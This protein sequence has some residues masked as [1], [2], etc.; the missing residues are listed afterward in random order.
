LSI[1]KLAGQAADF[2]E[3]P[4][5]T[6]LN[7]LKNGWPA[8][9]ASGDAELKIHSVTNPTGVLIGTAWWSGSP[10]YQVHV[11]PVD[12]DVKLKTLGYSRWRYFDSHDV[13]IFAK[14]GSGKDKLW[15]LEKEV[16]KQLMLKVEAPGTGISWMSVDGPRE[17]PE[18]DV[19]SEVYHSVTHVVLC[20]HKIRE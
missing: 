9:G 11:R 18:E 15:K 14:G 17:V 10:Y 16:M 19:R 20:Y 1:I 4:N 12:E 5:I 2:S 13:H 8:G 3:D 7:I 6:I